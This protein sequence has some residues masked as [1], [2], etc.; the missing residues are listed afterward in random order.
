MQPVLSNY[1]IRYILLCIGFITAHYI[2][3]HLYIWLC[4]PYGVKGYVMSPFLTL[5]PHCQFLRWVTYNGGVCINACWVL[6]GSWL[7]NKCQ[8]LV[9]NIVGAN[10]KE[11]CAELPEEP[12]EPK[13]EKEH[14]PVCQEE[15][16]ARTK[17]RTLRNRMRY[18]NAE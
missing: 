17:L 11:K 6:L 2:S 14:T 4:V 9:T 7:I 12:E 5:T 15:L 8:C 1:I 16:P 18:K 13:E 3:A 10:D